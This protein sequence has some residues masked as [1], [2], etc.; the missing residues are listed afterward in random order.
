[1]L[2]IGDD[3]IHGEEAY[4]LS[5]PM[6]ERRDVIARTDPYRR[7]SHDGAHDSAAP[8]VREPHGHIIP[9]SEL[10]EM[11]LGNQYRA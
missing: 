6:L 1:M 7:M 10:R 8:T 4:S 9:M 3:A 5:M 2:I 11:S